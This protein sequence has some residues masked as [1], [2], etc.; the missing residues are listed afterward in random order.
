[1][2][3][4]FKWSLLVLLCVVGLGLAWPTFETVSIQAPML[5]IPLIITRNGQKVPAEQI[6]SVK[7]QVLLGPAK[8]PVEV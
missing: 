6:R 1:M 4:A 2:S 8:A 7:Y 5:G 3:R